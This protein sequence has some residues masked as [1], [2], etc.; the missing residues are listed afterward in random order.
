MLKANFN[1][2]TKLGRQSNS[3]ISFKLKQ[4]HRVQV[5]RPID[6]EYVARVELDDDDDATSEFYKTVYLDWARKLPLFC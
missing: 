6:Y 4:G 5:S 3:P 1:G 2:K